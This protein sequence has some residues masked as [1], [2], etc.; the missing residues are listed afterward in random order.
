MTLIVLGEV[1][2]LIDQVPGAV[3]KAI[4]RAL[5]N[6]LVVE[7]RVVKHRLDLGRELVAVLEAASARL[8]RWLRRMSP[9]LARSGGFSILGAEQTSCLMSTRI[10]HPGW[11]APE[12]LARTFEVFCDRQSRSAPL[13]SPRGRRD[14]PQ[15]I[16]GIVH[17]DVADDLRA[18]RL[19]HG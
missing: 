2:D 13:R 18:A 8:F 14:V 16:G 15:P 5:T 3:A 9:G 6:R 4:L 12:R 11:N 17:A 7:R 1:L 19:C 10:A